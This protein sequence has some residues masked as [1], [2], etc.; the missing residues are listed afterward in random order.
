MTTPEVGD[1]VVVD[2]VKCRIREISKGIATCKPS[3]GSTE[4]RVSLDMIAWDR[5]AGLWR[6]K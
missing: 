5:I 4:A 2:G 3:Y 1:A 6:V